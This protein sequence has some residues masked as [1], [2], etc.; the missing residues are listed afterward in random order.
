MW[1]VLVI[2]LYE[3]VYA[4]RQR[5]TKLNPN[6]DS[7]LCVGSSVQEGVLHFN[8]RREDHFEVERRVKKSGALKLHLLIIS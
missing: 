5:A 3:Y 8:S 6:T 2:D 1:T 4:N 7:V